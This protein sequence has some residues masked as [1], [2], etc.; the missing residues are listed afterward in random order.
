MKK[1][2]AIIIA[3][4]GLTA[5]LLLGGVF[6]LDA[7]LTR[8]VLDTNISCKNQRFSS[9]EEAFQAWEAEE[10]ELH[11]TS[12]DYCPPYRVLYSFEYDHNTI[13]V[14]SYCDSFDSYESSSYAVRILKKNADGTLSFDC[15]F[16]DL[17][18]MEPDEAGNNYYYYYYTPIHT[19]KGM[20]T[21]SFLYLDIDSE[22]DIWVDGHKAE[23]LPVSIDGRE[24]TLCYAVS[25]RD[26]FLRNLLTPI[27]RR[28]S[29][30][31]R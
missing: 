26:S 30:K 9:A 13:V 19:S 1:K 18:L 24:F 17:K 6:C 27:D 11:D 2:T 31:C 4:V 25:H 14:F 23:K 20:K 12:L 21:I 8:M 10:R 3:C 28:H 29:I 22:K 16:A 15:G 7:I 5:V